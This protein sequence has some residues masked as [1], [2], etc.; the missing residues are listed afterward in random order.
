LQNE[1]EQ[2]LQ[3]IELMVNVADGEA[4]RRGVGESLD[5][6]TDADCEMN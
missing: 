1:F 4:P 3:N 6:D 5:D 2:S